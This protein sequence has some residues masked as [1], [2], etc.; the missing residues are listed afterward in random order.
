[1][2]TIAIFIFTFFLLQITLAQGTYTEEQ[3]QKDKAKLDSICRKSPSTCLYYSDIIGINSVFKNHTPRRLERNQKICFDKKFQYF[4]TKNGKSLRGCF[5]MNTRT[6]YVAQFMSHINESCDGLANPQTGFEL[7][8]TSKVRESFIFRISKRGERTFS[9]QMPMEGVPYGGSTNFV[10][11]NPIALASDFREPFT[12]QN[13]PTVP[14]VIEGISESSSKY[15]FG[16]Y[17]APRI[18]LKDYAGAFGTGYYADSLGNTFICLA[19]ESEN[20]FVKIEKITDV[21]ECFDGSS[22]KDENQDNIQ[23]SEEL[24]K[25]KEKDLDYQDNLEY[26]KNCEAGAA[27][28]LHK[29]QILEK[30]KNYTDFIKAG[31][32]PNGKDGLRIGAA[33]QDVIDQVITHRLETEKKICAQDYSIY[34]ASKEYN[35]EKNKERAQNKKQCLSAAVRQLDDLQKYLEAINVRNGTNFAK[36]VREK[37]LLYLNKMKEIDTSCNLDKAGNIK[38]NPLENG[39]KNMGEQL[40]EIIKRK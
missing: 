11:K 8:I 12:N 20:N 5:Y 10:L 28:V 36:A 40:K 39:A 32:N 37:N 21:N 38:K 7:M 26:N 33:A 4:A 3:R 1:M 2:K 24:I 27:L 13:L 34:V 19:V 29:R 17:H 22:F 30:E 6:G 16:A 23:T 31:G 25:E 18:P 35:G 15:L 9:A 14:Y